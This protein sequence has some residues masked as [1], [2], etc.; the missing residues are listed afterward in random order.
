M[1]SSVFATLLGEM[2]LDNIVTVNQT[3]L[4]KNF[5]LISKCLGSFSTL[6]ESIT[7]YIQRLPVWRRATTN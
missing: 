5:Q 7:S 3:S 1:A 6:E 4:A 2:T